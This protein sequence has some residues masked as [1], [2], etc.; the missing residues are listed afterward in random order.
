MIRRLIVE[1]IIEERSEKLFLEFIDRI[2]IEAPV[3]LKKPQNPEQEKALYKLARWA[4]ERVKA[5]KDAE[6]AITAAAKGKWDELFDFINTA[7]MMLGIK[8]VPSATLA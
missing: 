4:G 8:T 7:F 5:V 3:K 1:A 6:E 2:L